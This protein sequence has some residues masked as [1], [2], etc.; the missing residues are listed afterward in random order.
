MVPAAVSKPRST[1]RARARLLA[2]LA[3]TTLAA[4][5]LPASPAAAAPPS[6]DAPNAPLAF[7]PQSA[8]NGAPV[9]QQAIADLA[10]ATPDRGV[11]R[12]LGPQSFARTV[13]FVVQPSSTPQEITVE[14]A[15]RTLGV[16][17]LAAFVQLPNGDPL[18]PTTAV[19]NACGGVGSG[20]ADAAEEPTSG[21]T[22]RVPAG[23][24]VLIQA[25]RRG[26]PRSAEDERAV[27]SLDVTA[28]PA[29]TSALPGD[30]A[31]AATPSA[32][33]NRATIV[34]IAGATL[35][36]EDP[37]EPPCPSLGSVWRR[38]VPKQ[39]GPRVISVEGI[40]A[41]TLTVFNGP[42]PTTSNVLDCVN[43]V[44]RGDIQ[45]KVKTRA[46]RPLWIRIGTDQPPDRTTAILEILPGAGVFV[47][48]GGPAGSDP[49][50]GGPG[51]GLPFECGKAD[52]TVARL[53]GPR[54]GGRAKQLTR[55]GRIRVTL[56]LKEGPVCD[57]AIELVGPRGRVYATGRV[58]RLKSGRR[59]VFLRRSMRLV[60][61]SYRVRL[62]ALSRLGEHVTVRSSVKGRLR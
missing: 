1:K 2:V 61:G 41:T 45:M 36:G 31:D 7:E 38:I 34:P 30:N 24:A 55:R 21:V 10:E 29:P 49:T 40:E 4:A 47:A 62:T 22:L 12:C 58:L 23:R 9:D 53:T 8:E 48:D 15:G 3:A 44:G 20:G 52:A 37:A 57:V 43:R 51:G 33:T 50:T 27:L 32:H 59:G 56:N 17:D 14:A 19:P 5:A 26:T 16:L 39:G 42:K 60:R 28:L 6:N 35:T 18:N 46:R 11:P 25:G 13:W 54:I